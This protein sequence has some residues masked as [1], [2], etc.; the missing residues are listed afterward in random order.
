MYIDVLELLAEDA[1]AGGAG[2]GD[3]VAT[4]HHEALV[5]NV[6][7]YVHMYICIYIYIM[8]IYTYIYIY[9]YI[10]IHIYI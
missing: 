7:G 10:H 6:W 9:I 5:Y 2:V 8:F 4:L 1:L 3:E